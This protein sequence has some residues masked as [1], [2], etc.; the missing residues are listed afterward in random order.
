MMGSKLFGASFLAVALSIASV[1]SAAAQDP[2]KVAPDMYKLL[3]ENDR[4]RVMEVSFKPGSKIA[5][6]SHPDHMVYA[7]SAG[8]L[9]IQKPDGSAMD[10]D[11]KVGDILWIPAETHWAENTGTTDVRLLVTELKE[12]APAKPKAA[13]P[14][15]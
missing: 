14:T 6:H 8:K 13:A 12:P 4:I 2:L 10:A 9:K 5:K 1:H 7:L 3:H 11:I 15:K